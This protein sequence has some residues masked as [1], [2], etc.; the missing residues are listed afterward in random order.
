MVWDFLI[1]GKIDLVIGGADRITESGD[2]ANKIGTYSVAVLAKENHV[3]FYIAAPTSTI[4]LGIMSGEEIII[5]ERKPEEVTFWGNHKTAPEGLKVANP[6]FD[7]TPAKYIT[8]IIT[9]KGMIKP[10]YLE[11]ISMI[12]KL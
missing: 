10:D 3:P 1:S 8:G 4:D 12:F 11:N 5:E 6:A 7:V 2:T 9:E